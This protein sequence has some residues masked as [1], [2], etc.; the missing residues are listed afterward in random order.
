MFGLIINVSCFLF[1][2]KRIARFINHVK[3]NIIPNQCDWWLIHYCDVIMSAMASQIM[4]LT[5]VYSTIHSGADQRKHQSS[6]SLAFVRGI[7][8]KMFPFD[9]V[10]MFQMPLAC[11]TPALW[12]CN[13]NENSPVT[14]WCDETRTRTSSWRRAQPPNW[15]PDFATAGSIAQTQSSGK[16]TGGYH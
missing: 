2:H 14:S 3:L 4:S 5:V 11:L 9:D 12:R 15:A 6:A 16:P 7:N 1:H 8:R 10:I 13:Q